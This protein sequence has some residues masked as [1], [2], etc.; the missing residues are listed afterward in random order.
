[1]Q[2][3]PSSQTPLSERIQLAKSKY[4]ARLYNEAADVYVDCVDEI[5]AK[6][7]DT[8]MEYVD[9]VLPYSVSLFRYAQ[10]LA[11][12]Q[13]LKKAN[14]IAMQRERAESK[15]NSSYSNVISN[16]SDEEDDEEEE[17]EEEN[18]EEGSTVRDKLNSDDTTPEELINTAWAYMDSVRGVV[19][20]RLKE[21]PQNTSLKLK[22]AKAYANL[23][24]MDSELE[25]FDIAIQDYK[26]AL[27]YLQDKPL[28]ADM[29]VQIAICL[30]YLGRENETLPFYEAAEQALKDYSITLQDSDE[31]KQD[32]LASL[33]DI[34][35][36]I[37]EIKTKNKEKIDRELHQQF[38]GVSSSTGSSGTEKVVHIL[39]PKRKGDKRPLEVDSTTQEE[40][41]KKPRK[42]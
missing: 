32:V 24:D 2:D 11:K 23:G 15:A 28:I 31:S 6:Y 14:E 36:R 13:I 27:D 19:S 16:L 37:E 41:S 10:D 25:Q 3:E 18:A 8:S 33:E 5:I 35:I 26:S 12:L 42:Q 7:G 22:L 4:D 29:N 39:Q 1:M 40:D 9:V 21:D 30:M 17:E 38:S 20:E 34:R